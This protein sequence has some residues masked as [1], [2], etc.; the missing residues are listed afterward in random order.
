MKEREYD[1]S[2]R[3][4]LVAILRANVP[5][6][7][8]P[9]DIPDFEA[10]LDEHQ[11]DM[12]RVYLD[13]DERPIGCAGGY[14]DA[15]GAIGLTWMFFSPGSIGVSGIRSE[16]R[17]HLSRTARELEP[18]GNPIQRVNTTP[19]IG[20]FL[21]RFRFKQVSLEPDGFAPGYDKVTMELR[22]A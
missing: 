6:Y 5:K 22:G 13:K 1:L 19:R 2:D 12:N 16:L 4:A 14:L 9:S 3:D 7:F 20:R 11:W 17:R 8:A 10:Y 15:N 21:T 18:E